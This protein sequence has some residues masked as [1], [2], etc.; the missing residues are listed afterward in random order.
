M[1]LTK[2]PVR[3]PTAALPWSYYILP[4]TEFSFLLT[5]RE[6]LPV[7][8]AGAG[9]LCRQRAFFV[10]WAY[11]SKAFPPRLLWPVILNLLHLSGLLV[12][13]HLLSRFPSVNR[14]QASLDCA[15]SLFFSYCPAPPGCLDNP[16]PT[17]SFRSPNDALADHPL[18]QSTSTH[19]FVLDPFM[20]LTTCIIFSCFPGRSLKL[21][22]ILPAI[23]AHTILFL[24]KLKSFL[25]DRH[26]WRLYDFCLPSYPL[27]S[28]SPPPTDR[29]RS[30][31]LLSH[32]N[33]T[34]LFSPSEG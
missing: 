6:S 33:V 25:V 27:V 2:P 3:P 32:N 5:S 17:H 13:A 31:L 8:L 18:L 1:F 11:A 26:S 16:F 7:P 15:D 28:F 23:P 34:P 19:A 29:S 14:S 30:C 24:S 22:S 21:P 9:P 10:L 12:R 4:H 20:H